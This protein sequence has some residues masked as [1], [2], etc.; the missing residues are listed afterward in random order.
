MLK[1]T[2]HPTFVC[3]DHS[4]EH[5]MDI[6]TVRAPFTQTRTTGRQ[7]VQMRAEYGESNLFRVMFHNVSLQAKEIPGVK[8]FRSSATIYYTNAE[9][10]LEA[11]Q[12]KVCGITKYILFALSKM[13]LIGFLQSL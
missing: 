7:K 1:R 10:Y 4:E 11:L 12:E 5:S 8:I 6:H 9:M 3:T 2:L 13:T